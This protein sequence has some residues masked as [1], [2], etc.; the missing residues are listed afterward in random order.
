MTR[1]VI[2]VLYNGWAVEAAEGE[3]T[4]ETVTSKL[5][6]TRRQFL[7]FVG[8]EARQWRRFAEERVSLLQV[9][10]RE[11]FSIPALERRLLVRLDGT[12]RSLDGLVKDRLASL[13]SKKQSAARRA[14]GRSRKNGASKVHAP[15]LAA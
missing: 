5:L 7:V 2:D 1:C 8:S 13:G 10:V 6:E 11:T 3:T 4:V 9:G 12:L 15:S 14:K